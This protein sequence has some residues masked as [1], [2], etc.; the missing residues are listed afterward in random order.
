M[1]YRPAPTDVEIRLANRT[2]KLCCRCEEICNDYAT[3][4]IHGAIEC[5]QCI[6]WRERQDKVLVARMMQQR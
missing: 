1:K 2:P 3:V 6:Q 5:R 4:S